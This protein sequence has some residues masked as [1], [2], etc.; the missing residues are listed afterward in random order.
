M[1]TYL[2]RTSGLS[3]YLAKFGLLGFSFLLI[4]LTLF[5]KRNLKLASEKSNA[6]HNFIFTLFILLITFS[7]PIILEP[8]FLILI[9][10]YFS[11]NGKEGTTNNNRNF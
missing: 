3:D 7:N 4:S 2:Q 9:V 10:E 8:L 11:K 5:A 6:S 1:Y